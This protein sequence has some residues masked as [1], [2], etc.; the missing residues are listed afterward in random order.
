MTNLAYAAFHSSSFR[1]LA[2]SS[3]FWETNRELTEP[4]V[5][6]PVT[7]GSSIVREND[8]AVFDGKVG[9]KKSGSRCPTV[10]VIYPLVAQVEVGRDRR[11]VV[12]RVEAV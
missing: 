10:L 1:F 2:S 7:D 12:Y 6:S 8:G 11:M 3:S 4:L 9:L 5:W